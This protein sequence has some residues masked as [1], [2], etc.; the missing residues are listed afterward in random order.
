MSPQQMR[1][2]KH[3]IGYYRPFPWSRIGVERSGSSSALKMLRAFAR[4]E[5]LRLQRF[6]VETDEQIKRPLDDRI[7]G[8]ELLAQLRNSKA[9]GIAVARLEHVFTSSGQALSSLERWMDEGIS[10]YCAHFIL[11]SPLL[12][13]PKGTRLS[14][15]S[16]ISGLAEF[17]RRLD[18][19]ETRRRVINKKNRASWTGRVPFG[20][21]LED[22]RLIEDEDRI[23]RIQQ[24]KRAHRNGRSYRQIAVAQGISVGTAHRLV[25]TDLRRL[26]RIS[27][28]IVPLDEANETLSVS[29]IRE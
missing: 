7:V 16:L 5:G 24:M 13:T 29:R 18:S 15:R 12:L 10:F 19:E 6:L 1:S 27:R 4:E 20:F 2:E 22:G 25:R 11:E 17:Q 9:K 21:R 8:S 28:V 26:R 23:E 14:S 3:V